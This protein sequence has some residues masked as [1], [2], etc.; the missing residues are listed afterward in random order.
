M[1][2]QHPPS[3]LIDFATSDSNTPTSL[4]YSLVD[5][6]S[7]RLRVVSRRC[8]WSAMASSSSA[9]SDSVAEVSASLTSSPHKRTREGESCVASVK[10]Q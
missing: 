3:Y 5:A 8:L 10:C 1:L 7:R 9:T 2:S 4:L 6:L